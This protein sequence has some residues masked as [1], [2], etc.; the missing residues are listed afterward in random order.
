M[1]QI[2]P[3]ILESNREK[4][5][6]KLY[7]LSRLSGVETIQ[8]DFC[9]GKFVGAQTLLP[10]DIEPLNPI[11]YWEAH[12]MVRE[13]SDFLDYKMLGFSKI[14]V[15]YES[16]A[17]ETDLEKAL[18]NIVALG[19]TPAIAINPETPVSTLRYHTDTIKHFTLLSV[20]PGKQG[21]PF[22]ADTPTRLYE[23]RKLAPNAI[24]EIDGGITAREAGLLAQ[25]GADQL[26][27]GS[28]LFSSDRVQENFDALV[29]AALKSHG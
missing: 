25:N 18:S 28:A 4:F 20:H 9:D 23:L 2:V 21:N 3:A 12:M 10:K 26:A 1:A 7:Q 13:P 8:V 5:A 27:V 16:Y 24:L 19:L 29:Q 22:L 11:F 17:S 14:I 15:H 6:D